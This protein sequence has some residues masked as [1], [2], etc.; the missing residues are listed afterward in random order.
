M[1]NLLE[2]DAD[3]LPYTQDLQYAKRIPC[4]EVKLPPTPQKKEMSL[5]CILS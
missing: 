4:R 1:Y 3:M 5:N 2:T